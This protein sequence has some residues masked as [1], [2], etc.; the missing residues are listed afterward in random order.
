MKS[1]LIG[2]AALGILL[3]ACASPDQ[4]GMSLKANDTA[5][6][7]PTPGPSSPVRIRIYNRTEAKIWGP[8]VVE[9]CSFYTLEAFVPFATSAPISPPPADVAPWIPPTENLRFP[10]GYSGIVSVVVSSTQATTIT[11]GEIPESDLPTCSGKPWT[12]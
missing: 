10:T 3:V 8:P 1:L 6:A 4:V 7:M 12:P 5:T 2:A 11:V 9:P